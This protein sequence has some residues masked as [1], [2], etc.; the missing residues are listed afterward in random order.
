MTPELVGDVPERL[1]ASRQPKCARTAA[2]SMS[3]RLFPRTLTEQAQFPTAIYA[4]GRNESSVSVGCDHDNAFVR[5][6]AFAATSSGGRS[7][8]ELCRYPEARELFI[9]A[10]A[11]L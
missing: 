3:A 9:I 11:F 2:E 7:T 8:R 1:V 6:R 5:T 4:I 10:D